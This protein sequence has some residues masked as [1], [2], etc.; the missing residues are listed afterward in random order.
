MNTSRDYNGKFL[1]DNFLAM[2][3]G[4][5]YQTDN[6]LS[7]RDEDKKKLIYCVRKDGNHG[8]QSDET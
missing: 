8:V 3:S 1:D 6:K 2:L 7:G 5:T 4:K